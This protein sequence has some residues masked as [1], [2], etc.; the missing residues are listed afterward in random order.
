[1]KFPTALLIPLMVTLASGATIY[2]C[3]DKDYKSNCTNLDAPAGKCV[4][5]PFF[6]A[7]S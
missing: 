6:D 7:L 3:T 1:M 4:Q 5:I 2:V